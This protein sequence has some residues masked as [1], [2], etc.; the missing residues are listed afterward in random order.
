TASLITVCGMLGTSIT[1]AVV[2]W[3]ITASNNKASRERDRLRT[4]SETRRERQD[5]RFDLIISHTAD[6][7]AILDPDNATTRDPGA[8]ARMIITAQLHLDTTHPTECVLHDS[9]TDLGLSKGSDKRT[10]LAASDRVI[11]AAQSFATSYY[12]LHDCTDA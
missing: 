9:M 6:V 12:R 10:R 5:K 7:L 11:H 2:Q 1:A 8:L 4:Q 3:Y